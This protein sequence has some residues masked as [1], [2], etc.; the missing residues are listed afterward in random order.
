M[1][2]KRFRWLVVAFA[3]LYV[4]WWSLPFSPYMHSES[5]RAA[6]EHNGQ[7][8]IVPPNNTTGYLFLF[9]TL[10]AVAGLF[11]Y[12]AWARTLLLIT[13]IAS[14]AFSTLGGI[15]VVGP[16]DGTLGYASTLLNGVVLAAA[17]RKPAVAE[18]DAVTV[19][20][21]ADPAT[22]PA[23]HSLLHDAGI[24]SAAKLTVRRSDAVVAKDVMEL[25]S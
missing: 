3:V 15:A 19:Y 8:A 13:T 22:L 2:G 17:Y 20:E 6:L 7:G 18:D 9:A 1:T 12:Q 23:V 21:T 11:F 16:F 10:A 25:G 24:E 14:V 4:W 5:L